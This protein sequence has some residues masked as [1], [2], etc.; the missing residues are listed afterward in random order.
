MAEK[1]T[2]LG[3]SLA[4]LFDIVE[5]PLPAGAETEAGAPEPQKQVKKANNNK[6]A[7]AAPVSAVSSDSVLYVDID[8]LKPNSMQPRQSF[9]EEAIE[10]LASSIETYGVIQ[11]IILRKAKVGYEIV[12]GERRWRAARKAGLRKIPAI[13]REFGDEEN[14]LIAI[15]ENMQR[16]DLNTVEEAMAFKS[17]IGKYK[18]TQEELSKAVGKSRP[19][20]ANTLRTLNLPPDVIDLLRTGELTL[21]HANA[22]GAIKNSDKQ[23]QLAQKIAKNGLSVREAERLA[24]DVAQPKPKS[25]K[26]KTESKTNEMRLV[27]QE[28]TSLLGMRVVISGDRSKGAVELRYLDK[29]GL[30][31]IVEYLRNAGKNR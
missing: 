8:D 7:G 10:E 24:Q 13:I 19:H 17:V 22:L 18:L 28:L 9:A 31:D 30:D 21:G 15:I 29:S 27:E 3:K 23:I 4:E 25:S 1:R 12:A 11:P 6:S 2:G 5:I 14:A 16:E 20:I 26:K